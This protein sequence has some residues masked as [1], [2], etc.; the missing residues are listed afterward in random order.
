MEILRAGHDPNRV[1]HA[2]DPDVKLTKAEW[3]EAEQQADHTLID[4]PEK[5]LALCQHLMG[6]EERKKGFGSKRSASDSAERDFWRLGRFNE[7]SSDFTLR[8]A[9]ENQSSA[10]PVGDGSGVAI[11]GI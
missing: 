9:H 8:N 4:G 11:G 7:W 10:N 3:L 2:T 1:R 6:H 5:L